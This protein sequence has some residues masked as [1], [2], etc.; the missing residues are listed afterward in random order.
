MT[1]SD[2]DECGTIY[3]LTAVKADT[4][5][6]LSHHD[7]NRDTEDVITLF[8]DIERRRSISSPIPVFISDNWTPFVE[9]LINVYGTLEQTPYKGIGRKPLPR[10]NP[11][12]DLKYAQVCKKR[13]KGRVVEVVQRV[14]YGD[15]DEVLSILGAD[16]GG[17]INT[18][19]VERINLT[20]RNSLARFIRRGM[21]CSKNIQMHSRAIDFFQAWY[22]F[23]KPHKSLRI[24]INS[25][26]RRWREMT[27]VMAEKLTDHIWT[28]GELMSFRIPIQ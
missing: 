23:V 12:E 5:L 2:P 16:S 3:S 19:Y 15:V 7:G 8:K 1:D 10:L 14:V 9:G 13:V 17:C 26:N 27:P 21:N 22:N 6:F 25:G 20:I 11:Y 24:E 18:S 4:R 28:L